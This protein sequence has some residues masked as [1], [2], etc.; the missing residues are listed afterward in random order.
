MGPLLEVA[1]GAGGAEA[2]A[3]AGG[4]GGLSEA[5]GKMPEGLFNDRRS[6][7]GGG[8]G[9][10]SGGGGSDPAGPLNAVKAAQGA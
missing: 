9:N 6:G 3:E 1:G 7:G 4:G 10:K 5:M 8:G 2:G